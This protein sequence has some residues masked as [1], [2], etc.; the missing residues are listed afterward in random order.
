MPLGIVVV[1]GESP[2]R[3]DAAADGVVMRTMGS[4]GAERTRG[5][6]VAA[7]AAVVAVA[8]TSP[9]FAVSPPPLFSVG[10]AKRHATLEARVKLPLLLLLGVAA[11]A[12]RFSEPLLKTTKMAPLM[13]GG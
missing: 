2:R 11:R 13:Y 4:G 1:V 3:C 8:A 12:F 7:V 9:L 10:N 5:R 6:V